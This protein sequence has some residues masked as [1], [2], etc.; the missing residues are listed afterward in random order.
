MRVGVGE[1][2][3]EKCDVSREKRTSIVAKIMIPS[4][5]NKNFVSFRA[6]SVVKLLV[7]PLNVACAN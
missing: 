6:I 3:R 7:P 4:H 1:N 2:A 5:R